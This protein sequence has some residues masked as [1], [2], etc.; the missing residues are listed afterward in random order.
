[1]SGGK[2][3][4]DISQDQGASYKLLDIAAPWRVYLAHMKIALRIR[5][6]TRRIGKGIWI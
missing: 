3:R 4:N 6:N 1:M 2:R 5:R